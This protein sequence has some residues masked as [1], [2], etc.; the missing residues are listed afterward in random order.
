MSA[1]RQCG[2]RGKCGSAAVRQSAARAFLPR[3]KLASGKRLG[4]CGKC[5]SAARVPQFRKSLQNKQLNRGTFSPL[6]GAV[7]RVPHFPLW[8]HSARQEGAV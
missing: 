4:K 7:A 1:V 8:G 2:N 6:T 5:G 3:Y